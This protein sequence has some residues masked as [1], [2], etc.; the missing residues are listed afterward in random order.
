MG[1]LPFNKNRG[2]AKTIRKK[3][4]VLD[5]DYNN[6]L[7]YSYDY[8]YITVWKDGLRSEYQCVSFYDK[9][10]STA[11]GTTENDVVIYIKRTNSGKTTEFFTITQCKSAHSL[12]SYSQSKIVEIVYFVLSN[13]NNI[14]NYL[15]P[16]IDQSLIKAWQF[17]SR[18]MVCDLNTLFDAKDIPGVSYH[19]RQHVT[20]AP[21]DLLPYMVFR[22]NWNN[23]CILPKEF[24]VPIMRLLISALPDDYSHPNFYPQ[25]P[26]AGLRVYNAGASSLAAAQ[27]AYEMIRNGYI[28]LGKSGRVTIK[29]LKQFSALSVGIPPL[30]ET[31][32]EGEPQSMVPYMLAVGFTTL[33]TAADS[34][35]YMKQ[36]RKSLKG[37]EVVDKAINFKYLSTAKF[38]SL[39]FPSA[40]VFARAFCS[41]AKETVCVWRFI[42]QMLTNAGSNWIDIDEICRY[43]GLFADNNYRAF[44]P[45]SSD[46]FDNSESILWNGKQL[47]TDKLTETVID[48]SIRGSLALMAVLGMVELAIDDNARMNSDLPYSG[49]SMAHLTD[50]G[51]FTLGLS[52]TYESPVVELDYSDFD[53]DSDHLIVTVNNPQSP[54]MSVLERIAKKIPGNRYLVD[55]STLVSSCSNVDEVNKAIDG[56]KKYVCKTLPPLWRDFFR[57]VLQRCKPL[58]KTKECYET[59][60]IDPTNDRLIELFSTDRTLMELTRRAEDFI[61]LIPTAKKEGVQKR[62]KELGYLL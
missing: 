43:K 14:I 27:V 2:T 62:L 12:D 8:Y 25:E 47:E 37:Y 53:V 18:T 20:V 31:E 6:S 49:I 26:L 22:I 10:L 19:K 59:Y 60:A 7:M 3:A 54:F 52:K 46:T 36:H 21:E 11:F 32:I 34:Q 35:F 13:E 30:F 55:A 58:E 41:D 23:Y 57:D 16:H 56:F 29:S 44:L 5:I 38:F 33:V 28:D 1:R 17:M 50:F 51:R 24:V 40:K 39:L 48:S 42:K 9:Y 15:L 4:V 61:V 45:W